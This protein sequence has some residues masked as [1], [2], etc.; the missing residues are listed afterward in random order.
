[1]PS[2][3]GKD[4]KAP[5]I[6]DIVPPPLSTNIKPDKITFTLDEFFSVSEPLK[7]ILVSPPLEKLPVIS[8]KGKKM[9]LKLGS[10]LIDDKTYIFTLNDLIKDINE[11]VKLE[12]FQYVFSTGSTIDSCIVTG[13]VVS[14]PTLK[15]LKNIWIGLYPLE[16]K[17]SF[18][19]KQPLYLTKTDISGS[20]TI[21]YIKKDTYY[22]YALDD[23]NQNV[24]Y[25]L[26]NESIGLYDSHISFDSTNNVSLPPITLFNDYSSNSL[27]TH[28]S[29]SIHTIIS[30]WFD[31][32]SNKYL[33]NNSL[34]SR[35]IKDSMVFFNTNLSD[36]IYDVKFSNGL[37]DTT[38]QITFK[39]KKEPYSFRVLKDEYSFI[40]DGVLE[41]QFSSPL[42]SF[43]GNV[44]I[45]HDSLSY[46]L[47]S[48]ININGI[49]SAKANYIFRP[50]TIYSLI[51]KDSCFTDIYD[52]YSTA[53][54]LSVGLSSPSDFGSLI[55][56]Y[57]KNFVEDSYIIQLYSK[58]KLVKSM[59]LSKS[60]GNV[61][62]NTLLP[63]SYDCLL[64]DDIDNNGSWS[65]GIYSQRRMPEKVIPLFNEINIRAKWEIEDSIYLKRAYK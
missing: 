36:S 17:D 22:L 3:G 9:I 51:F 23:K 47:D 33:F 40:N 15:P 26:P 8:I 41:I 54:T 29:S 28:S 35:A 12:N 55:L 11:G 62:F 20:F 32:D 19:S 57:D 18:I 38:F 61:T 53:S 52:N 50:G 56:N 31:F 14:G 1:M 60:M 10:G 34:I 21:K 59:H 44:Y 39:N 42:K 45:E 43:N 37:I 25:D 4:S 63:G 64:I 13:K 16:M 5:E 65:P 49:F 2:G 24:F 6:K 58:N 48:F 27:I 46:C 30:G 7:N